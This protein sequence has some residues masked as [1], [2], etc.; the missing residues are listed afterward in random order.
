MGDHIWGKYAQ[1]PK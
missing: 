1:P